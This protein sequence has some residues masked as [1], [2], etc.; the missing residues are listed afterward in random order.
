MEQKEY[1]D[2]LLIITKYSNVLTKCRL[3]EAGLYVNAA[4]LVFAE[5]EIESL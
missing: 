2:D 3:Q 4:K 5:S 1:L